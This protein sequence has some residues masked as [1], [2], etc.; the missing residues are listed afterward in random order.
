MAWKF[1][2]ACAPICCT[3]IST[4]A[5]DVASPLC[6]RFLSDLR[7][8]GSDATDRGSLRQ[9]AEVR[10]FVGDADVGE[11]RACASSA[12]L[13][14]TPSDAMIMS[15]LA[16]E[17]AKHPLCMEELESKC[18]AET[19]CAQKWYK[20]AIHGLVVN[21][22]AEEA[23]SMWRRAKAVRLADGKAPIAWP[24]PSQ[25]PT[26]WVPGLESQTFWNCSRWPFLAS[27]EAATPMI[28]EE[29]QA[30]AEF[31][32]AYPYLKTHGVWQDIFLYRGHDW[33][34][35]LCD[36]MPATCRLLLPELPT[37]PGVPYATVYNEEVVI[38][39]SEPG[40]SVG[41]H[42]GSSNAVINLHLTLKGGRGT[43]VSVGDERVLLED[44]KVVC[45]QDSFFHSVEHDLSGEERISLVIRVMHPDLTWE[46]LDAKRTDVVPDLASFDR[47]GSLL[48]EIDRLRQEYRK[49]AAQNRTKL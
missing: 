40:A 10:R 15:H 27:L 46:A 20:I 1:W 18:E 8:M 26:V 35:S 41:A 47:S 5:V 9:L 39:R 49:L 34:T 14:A 17:V 37:K 31:M 22:L 4:D 23:E 33:N 11:V 36:R 28:L 13:S 12:V 19:R 24:S 29:V 43:S 3:G 7:A 21:G 25:T 30:A 32:S 2:A 42:C 48:S 16:E 45:F 38:F 6:Q 44:G